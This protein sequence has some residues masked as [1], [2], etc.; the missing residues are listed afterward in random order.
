MSI[1]RLSTPK[2]KKINNFNDTEA[3]FEIDYHTMDDRTGCFGGVMSCVGGGNKNKYTTSSQH[4]QHTAR[5]QKDKNIPYVNSFDTSSSSEEEELP[6]SSRTVQQGLAQS[7]SSNSPATGTPPSSTTISL[8][9]STITASAGSLSAEDLA[10][11]DQWFPAF[12]NID[13]MFEA[14]RNDTFMSSQAKA[15]SIEAFNQLLRPSLINKFIERTTYLLILIYDALPRFIAETHDPYAIEAV[16][17]HN[18]WQTVNEANGRMGGCYNL[19]LLKS[20]NH[21]H[22]IA[23]LRTITSD[24]CDFLKRNHHICNTYDSLQV[25]MEQ[26]VRSICTINGRSTLATPAPIADENKRQLEELLINVSL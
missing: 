20:E 8:P 23:L 24:W 7:H 26:N 18:R 9:S 10:F 17:R 16:E 2:T 6:L 13:A 1:L 3:C 25:A 12:E 21:S 5:N 14:Y 11:V 22:A 4:Q 15:A 19:S